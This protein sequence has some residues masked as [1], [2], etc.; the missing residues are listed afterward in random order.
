MGDWGAIWFGDRRDD[1]MLKWWDNKS[2]TTFCV[3]GNHCNYN[4]IKKLSI[5]EKF[6]GKVY[7]AG[8]SIFLGITGEIYNLNGYT[9]LVINGASSQDK[10]L[11]EKNISWW[12]EEDITEK[13]YQR[14]LN[15]LKK[16]NNKVDYVFSHTGGLEVCSFLGF[17]GTIS[18]SYLTRILRQI[19][20]KHHFCGHYHVDMIV[21]KKTR[22]LYNDVIEI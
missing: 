9:C 17:Q 3:L 21:D 15:N 2:W 4:A 1:Q 10:H 12:A 6:G 7:Q 8:N 22:I 19:E 5:V 14:A 16:Y 13:G 11:R 18:D 20:Y